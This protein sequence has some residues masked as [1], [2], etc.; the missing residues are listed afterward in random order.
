MFDHVFNPDVRA[1][2]EGKTIDEDDIIQALRY[3]EQC[4]VAD[5]MNLNV[6]YDLGRLRMDIALEAMLYWNHEGDVQATVQTLQEYW[7]T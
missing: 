1:V 5:C 6:P 7:L 3:T 4:A 2:L